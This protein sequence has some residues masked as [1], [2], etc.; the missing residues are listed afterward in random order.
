MR[1]RKYRRNPQLKISNR[2]F[3]A[4]LKEYGDI[5]KE[6]WWREAIQNSVDAGATQIDCKT[7]INEEAKT[8]LIQVSDNGRGMSQEILV[9]KFLAF[10]ETSKEGQE[11]SV[12][13]FGKAKELLILPWLGW[14][15]ETMD[16]AGQITG[17]TGKANEYEFKAPHT[18]SRDTQGTTL[19]VE[20]PI[21][22]TTNDN[23]CKSFI[24]KCFIPQTKFKVNGEEVSADL[25]PGKEVTHNKD[26]VITWNEEQKI[27]DNVKAIVRVKGVYMFRQYVYSEHSFEGTIVIELTGNSVDL[28]ATNRNELSNHDDR[29]FINKFFGKLEKDVRS[30]LR[31]AG[32]RVRKIYQ[33]SGKFST[34][35]KSQTADDL[36][37]LVQK[38]ISE[39]P[40]GKVE[41]TSMT[42]EQIK[43]ALKQLE[44]MANTE[45]A[46][47]KAVDNAVTPDMAEAL[48][49]DVTFT[50]DADSEAAMKQLL[51]EPDFFL[52][53]EI[54]DFKV[55]AE[56]TPEKM[57]P[58]AKRVARL[59]AAFCQFV[60]IQLGTYKEFGIGFIFS[61]QKNKG[62]TS[63]V[64]GE[65]VREDGQNWILINPY[66][67]GDPKSGQ[68]YDINNEE[69][70]DKMY[71]LAIHEC[72][73]IA[74]G[75]SYHDEDFS[76]AL[77]DNIAKTVRGRK[78]LRTIRD[79][80]RSKFK[81]YGGTKTGEARRSFYKILT[82]AKG[83][84]RLTDTLAEARA[85]ADVFPD[86]LVKIIGYYMPDPEDRASGLEVGTLEYRYN[87]QSY[88]DE[89]SQDLDVA[90]SIEESWEYATAL[91]KNLGYD[92]PDIWK[93]N[94]KKLSRKKRVRRH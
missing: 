8:V 50:G 17:V 46:T 35:D 87:G 85:Y 27:N 73:H 59:W 3:Q 55:P 60:F 63:W 81:L 42:L 29:A 37:H 75:V 82:G 2:L 74:D 77:T 71:A 4:P 51:W 30:G 43:E 83:K 13:G 52:V 54:K 20:M 47:P 65:Y 45:S 53:N 90:T 7:Y 41:L 18:I 24:R 78:N 6:C 72:T 39:K 64:Q 25:L 9:D 19:V 44:E 66:L 94:P 84:P 93:R 67:N 58:A 40:K 92:Y 23:I 21:D 34:Y 10:G 62:M 16:A 14:T 32:F 11:G 1:K 15:V 36:T 89:V 26:M 38:L 22:Q 91:T 79:A 57:G 5:W 80:V 61:Y 31:G 86:K 69:H 56:F 49:S 88:R 33:G 28:L 70:L 68:L 12:G 76:A 48:L